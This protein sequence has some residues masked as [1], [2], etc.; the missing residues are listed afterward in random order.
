MSH[1]AGFVPE[2]IRFLA[3]IRQLPSGHWRVQVRR[4][5]KFASETFFRRAHAREWANAAENQID[6]GRAPAGKR[7]RGAKTFGFSASLDEDRYGDAKSQKALLVVKSAG[8]GLGS[9]EFH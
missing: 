4:K 2:R 6:R 7:A 8:W 9:P 3:S 1:G 5:G